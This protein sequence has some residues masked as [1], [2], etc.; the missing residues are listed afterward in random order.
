MTQ[1]EAVPSTTLSPELHH[2]VWMSGP[3]NELSAFS[4]SPM[5]WEI[6]HDFRGTT[7]AFAPYSLH[8]P[9]DVPFHD[10]SFSPLQQTYSLHGCASKFLSPRQEV[11]D[12]SNSTSAGSSPHRPEDPAYSH[13]TML[14]H[15]PDCQVGTTQY[16]TLFSPGTA[17]AEAY[18]NH[19]SPTAR[20]GNLVPTKNIGLN[21]EPRTFQFASAPKHSDSVADAEF[22]SP[23]TRTRRPRSQT[24]TPSN[25]ARTH[26]CPTCGYV[27]TRMY[28]YNE[29]LKTHKANREKPHF[30]GWQNCTVRFSRQSD[31]ERHVGTVCVNRLSM[32]LC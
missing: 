10:S 1:A 22:L 12:Y 31:L 3:P 24:L 11:Y 18:G 16:S 21:S 20:V 30:C 27:F 4:A 7:S 9:P 2:P 19:P 14:Y 8:S 17:T 6:S 32:K 25:P 15:N 26:T 28:N 23:V 13:E 29:H 5:S